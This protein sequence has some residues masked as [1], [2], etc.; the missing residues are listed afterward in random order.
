MAKTRKPRRSRR[1]R[2]L[3]RWLAFSTAG[4]GAVG[5][6]LPLVPTT[7]FLL[8]SV[9][10]ANRSSPALHRKIRNHKHFA[11]VIHAWENGRAIPTWTKIFGC[12][13]L[14][15]SLTKLWLFGAPKP[16]LI[17]MAI[18]FSI[19]AGFMLSRPSPQAVAAI[20]S[21][22]PDPDHAGQAIQETSR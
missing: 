15:L 19:I 10:A 22:S 7:P 6:V 18:F 8:V 13:L 11:P 20:N 9:W 16:L 5:L 3:Y 12:S 14:A 1:V 21:D 2:I 4:L 17:G